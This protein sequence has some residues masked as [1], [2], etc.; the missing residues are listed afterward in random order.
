MLSKV[1]YFQK[2]KQKEKEVL[3]T[4]RLKIS[5]PKQM[6]QGIALTKVK[7]DNTSENLLHEIRQTIYYLYQAK[8]ITKKVYNNIMD[9]VKLKCKKTNTRSMSSK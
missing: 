3:R 7:A 4:Q 6:L 1:E 5:T 2:K 9:S 8:E